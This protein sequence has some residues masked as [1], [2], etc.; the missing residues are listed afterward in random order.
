MLALPSQG[1]EPSQLLISQQ[2][3]QVRPSTHL[4]GK[5][6]RHVDWLRVPH[7]SGR[8]QKPGRERYVSIEPVTPLF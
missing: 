8:P 2:I 5:V 6:I 3:G 7:E 1:P 4:D